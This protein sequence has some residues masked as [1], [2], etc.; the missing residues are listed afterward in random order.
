ML[1]HI[2]QQCAVYLACS[3]ATI[4]Q[5]HFF[6]FLLVICAGIIRFEKECTHTY[7]ISIWR[8][9]FVLDD[10][11]LSKLRELKIRAF[12]SE[13]IWLSDVVAKNVTT[14]RRIPSTYSWRENVTDKTMGRWC[15]ITTP[16]KIDA[17]TLQGQL[18][19]WLIDWLIDDWLIELSVDLIDWLRL[20]GLSQNLRQCQAQSA[21]L[22]WI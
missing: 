15:C 10:I 2:L 3:C 21:Y 22:G 7:F 4:Y 9:I 11:L 20:K 17:E 19:R 16:P 5:S 1:E 6:S 8:L 13:T 18:N 12:C 14:V